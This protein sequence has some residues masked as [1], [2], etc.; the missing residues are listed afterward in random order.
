MAVAIPIPE[1]MSVQDAQEMV[2]AVQQTLDIRRANVDPGRH[3]VFLRD[4]VSQGGWPR[5]R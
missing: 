1:R 4:Q 5:G 2:T 3:M